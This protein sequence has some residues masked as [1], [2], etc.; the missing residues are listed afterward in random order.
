MYANS[1]LATLNSRVAIRNAKG[2]TFNSIHLSGLEFNSDSSR[3]SESKADPRVR[4]PISWNR[5][6][7]RTQ[8]SFA[9]VPADVLELSAA[10][11]SRHTHIT[12][13]SENSTALDVFAKSKVNT[14]FSDIALFNIDTRSI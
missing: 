9:Q 10:N 2:S 13:E 6:G 11:N 14:H 12:E 3:R 7:T 1:L 4:Y 5:Q 8:S